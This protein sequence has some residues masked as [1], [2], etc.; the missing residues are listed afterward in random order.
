MMMFIM[1]YLNK[2]YDNEEINEYTG[3]GTG[4]FGFLPTNVLQILNYKLKMNKYDCTDSDSGVSYYGNIGVIKKYNSQ[5][6][7]D[8]IIYR[9][10]NANFFIIRQIH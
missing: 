9:Q 10:M 2:K 1:L 7:C 3:V 8:I 4:S 5:K 6:S